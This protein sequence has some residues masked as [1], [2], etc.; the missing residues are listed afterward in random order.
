M[1]HVQ[2]EA[3]FYL[4]GIVN[5]TVCD[6]F[7]IDSVFVLSVHRMN[8]HVGVYEAYCSHVAALASCSASKTT[9]DP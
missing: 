8:C 9:T 6:L 4:H 7:V 3:H 2:V 1:K 5:N